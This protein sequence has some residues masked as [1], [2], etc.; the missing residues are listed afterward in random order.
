MRKQ[1]LLSPAVEMVRH[2]VYRE[3]QHAAFLASMIFATPF[4][5]ILAGG[6]VKRIC[7][8]SAKVL[9]PE[10]V[11]DLFIFGAI[12]SRCGDN[13][14]VRRVSPSGRMLKQPYPYE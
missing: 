14:L 11:H 10:W 1:Y 8:R 4:C 5:S 2:F 13:C 7:V 12:E 3:M 9:Y 6:R